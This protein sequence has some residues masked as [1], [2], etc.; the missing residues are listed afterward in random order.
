MYDLEAE[1]PSTSRRFV[2]KYRLSSENFPK[3]RWD[4]D[5]APAKSIA[6]WKHKKETQAVAHCISKSRATLE[7]EMRA[8]LSLPKNNIKRRIFTLYPDPSDPEVMA[9]I[10]DSHL[11]LFEQWGLSPEGDALSGTGSGDD[12]QTQQVAAVDKDTYDEVNADIGEDDDINE[13]D[14][15]QQYDEDT[16]AQAEQAATYDEDDD[17][18]QGGGELSDDGSQVDYEPSESGGTDGEK[19]S[20]SAAITS[21]SAKRQ[22]KKPRTPSSHHSMSR[23]EGEKE[24]DI[25]DDGPREIDFGL[26]SDESDLSE[27]KQTQETPESQKYLCQEQLHEQLLD[28]DDKAIES[29]EEELIDERN[30]EER[31]AEFQKEYLIAR[32]E[33]LLWRSKKDNYMVA[34]TDK[35]SLISLGQY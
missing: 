24:M 16:N 28:D 13:T 30:S 35:S 10:D 11:L 22:K 32:S 26:Q 21:P 33:P 6:D 27:E 34:S 18:E 17:P 15:F 7:S 29:A 19:S 4:E 3:D 20:D 8:M 9:A 14:L 5:T 12:E 31:I 1:I 23:E 2:T 25:D